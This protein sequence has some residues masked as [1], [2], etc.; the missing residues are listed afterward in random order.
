MSTISVS[1]VKKLATH[2]A[3]SLDETEI[4]SMQADLSQIIEYVE[5][6]QAVDTDGV[7]P[8]YQVNYLDTV[9]RE[10][11]MI[12]YGIEQNDLLK[13]APQTAQGMII[14]PRVIE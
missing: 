1:D 13:N 6:L 7:E 5:Q 12:D 9:T 10:D 3:L 8:T 2:S 4:A 14:V 11:T